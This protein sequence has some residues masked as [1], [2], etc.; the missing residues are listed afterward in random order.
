MIVRDE[1]QEDMVE[2]YGQAL[3]LTRYFLGERE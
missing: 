1:L 2:T 3:A